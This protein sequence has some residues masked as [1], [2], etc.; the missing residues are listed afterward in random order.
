MEIITDMLDINTDLP[1]TFKLYIVLFLIATI[2]IVFVHIKPIINQLETKT[3]FYWFS[4]IVAINLFNILVTFLHY[5]M[6]T[7]TFKGDRGMKGD[8]GVLGNRGESIKCDK[9]DEKIELD[10]HN[11]FDITQRIYIN[12]QIGEVKRPYTRYG[13]YPLGYMI[14]LREQELETPDKKQSYVVAGA[15]LKHPTNFKLIAHIP[16]IK[17]KVNTPAYVWRPIPPKGYLSLGDIITEKSSRPPLNA[18]MCVP[19]NCVKEIRGDGYTSWR[20]F[21]QNMGSGKEEDYIFCSFW[22]TP[23]NTFYCNYPDFKDTTKNTTFYNGSL[24]YNIVDG[25]PEY[26]IWSD[27]SYQPKTDFAEKLKNQFQRIISPVNLKGERQNVGRDAMIT[28]TTKHTTT[29]WDAISHYFPSGF[30]FM[31][32]IDDMGDVKGG[33]RLSNIQKKIL[34]FAKVWVKPNIKMY[35]IHNKCLIKTQLSQEKEEIIMKIKQIYKDIDFLYVRYS[36][37]KVEL[38]DYLSE[39]YKQLVREMRHIPDFLERVA[40]NDFKH[41]SLNKLKT[42]EQRLSN[43]RAY[44]INF[45]EAETPDRRDAILDLI[46]QLRVYESQKNKFDIKLISGT[47]DKSKMKNI[48]TDF[49]D[50]WNSINMLYIGNSDYKNKLGNRNFDSIGTEKIKKTTQLFSN[51]NNFM[52]ST[53]EAYC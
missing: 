36:G 18:I 23:M 45:T 31:I 24:F 40:E 49:N 39:Q 16:S 7:G 6:R 51:L 21:Y 37:K 53:T 17:N 22:D 11:Q 9:C 43:I 13:F 42:L 1:A 8:A 3:P 19:N 26:L 5:N 34:K 25:N 15:L 35:I 44:I 12:G 29:L 27:N 32:S 33:M 30:M 14:S 2:L 52:V 20:F 38:V 50:L 28:D 46:K 4:I 41:F 10:I 47:C 48:E